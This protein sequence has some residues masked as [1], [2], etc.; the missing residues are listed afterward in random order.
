MSE[1]YIDL[2]SSIM[3]LFRRIDYDGQEEEESE[4]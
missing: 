1:I 2:K 3:K 4:T